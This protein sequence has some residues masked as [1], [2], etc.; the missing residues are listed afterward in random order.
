MITKGYAFC[1]WLIF[2]QLSSS[3]VFAGQ[4][5]LFSTVDSST[6][7]VKSYGAVGD[8]S[9]DDSKAMQDALNHVTAL[10]NKVIIP[11]GNYVISETLRTAFPST[12]IVF[13]KGAK[14]LLVNN[15][16]GG[17]L[18]MHDNS[19]VEN[20]TFQGNGV[21]AGNMYTGFGVLLGGVSGC[22]VKN[23][24]FSLISG[25]DIFLVRSK[26]KGCTNCTIANN[27]IISPVQPMVVPDMSAIIMG[28]SG[29]GY[30]HKNNLIINNVI[31]G[32]NTLGNGIAVMAHGSDNKIIGNHV[33]NCLRYGIISYETSYED[34]T[35][36][37]TSII[38]NT[39]EQIGA[40]DGTTTNMGMGIYIMKTHYSIIRGNTIT[41]VL[42]NA[43]NTETL[44]RGAIA[45]NGAVGCI[46]DSNTISNSNRYGIV[47]VYGFDTQIKY[48]KILGVKESGIYLRNTSGN[49][50]EYNE[51][52]DIGKLAIK[53]I[54]GSTG[55]PAYVGQGVLVKFRNRPTGSGIIINNNKFYTPSKDVIILSGEG[56]KQSP[57]YNNPMKDVLI[58]NN[59]LIGS[60]N[61]FDSAVKIYNAVPG[62]NKISRNSNN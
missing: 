61:S 22:V 9:K 13:E 2:M 12:H 21:L 57:G 33:K 29:T 17:I 7:N 10:R 47:C 40:K 15:K 46:I 60:R 11:V 20:G 30:S 55:N 59:K 36:T 6:I 25:C 42:R 28:Y 62:L 45:I 43:D 34:S 5:A 27:E 31:D 51:F 56:E 26:N 48:N 24:K 1:W 54:F 4:G 32:S 58:Q 39:V 3:F 14:I 41:N 44:G 35:L 37:A 8:G 53:G 19:S 52:R 23:C 50:I 18:L 49:S 16:K 38:D